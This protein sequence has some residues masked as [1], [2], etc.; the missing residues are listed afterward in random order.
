[1]LFLSKILGTI[2]YDSQEEN[3]GV[4]I[5]VVVKAKNEYPPV[6]GIEVSHKGKAFFIHYSNI[7]TLAEKF[8][9]LNIHKHALEKFHP[10]EEDLFLAKDLLERQIF[11]LQGVKLV[12]VNDILLGKIGDKFCFISV[13][14]GNKAIVNRLGLG[15]L[16]SIFKFEDRYIRWGDIN[17]VDVPH[18]H[19]TALQLRMISDDLTQLHPADIAN[20]IEDLNSKQSKQLVEAISNVSEEFAADV[21]EEIDVPHKLKNIVMGLSP[22]QAAV[23]LEN[24]ESDEAADLIANLPEE[25]AEELLSLINKEDSD[26]I[27]KLLIHDEYSVGAL[28]SSD[29][30]AVP[31]DYTVEQAREHIKKVSEE[32]NSIIYIYVVSKKGKLKG[33]VSIRTLLVEEPSTKIKSIMQKNMITTKPDD[34]HNEA[35]KKMTKYNLLAISVVNDEEKLI[36]IVTADDALRILVP[37]A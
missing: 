5:D 8:C 33:V 29:F 23:I 21:L 25:R 26:D 30:L 15:F 9:S 7:E 32:F 13:S 28:M 10:H 27:K 34:P 16:A 37:N 2:V 4:I 24:M 11:D 3:L 14:V 6:V 19:N 36:G 18:Q 35:L 1:M 20:I 17:L 22:E 12:R 31:V